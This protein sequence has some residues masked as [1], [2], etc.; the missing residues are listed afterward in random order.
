MSE[1]KCDDRRIY[2]DLN[3]H[4]SQQISTINEYKASRLCICHINQPMPI[5][6][7]PVSAF[8][9]DAPPYF[10]II[11]RVSLYHSGIFM[12]EDCVREDSVGADSVRG[13]L[14][15]AVS[16]QGVSS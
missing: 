2:T 3:D 16:V 4:T 9:K 12:R 7:F 5:I 10:Y 15:P 11:A 13:V 8:S 1:N 6:R 14:V